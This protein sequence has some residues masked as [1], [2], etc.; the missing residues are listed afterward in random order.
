MSINVSFGVPGT[1][2]KT[3][4]DT[5]FE[6]QGGVY[7]RIPCPLVPGAVA[8]GIVHDGHFLTPSTATP[9][10]FDVAPDAN[11]SVYLIFTSNAEVIVQQPVS[12]DEFPGS[13]LTDSPTGLFGSILAIWPVE[14]IFTGSHG[15]GTVTLNSY[16]AGTPLTVFNGLLCPANFGTVT[17]D[18]II[19]YVEAPSTVTGTNSVQCRINP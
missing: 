9:G 14:Q 16:T 1:L 3:F 15:G 4:N 5:K 8:A 7:S 18:R 19:G 17:G 6:L 10:Y 12:A 2:R 11:R 13:E